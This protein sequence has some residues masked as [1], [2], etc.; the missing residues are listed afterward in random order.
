[1]FV[2]ALDSI[3]ICSE[4]LKRCPGLVVTQR[5]TEFENDY[6]MKNYTRPSNKK[7]TLQ[8]GAEETSQYARGQKRNSLFLYFRHDLCGGPKKKPF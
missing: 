7:N 8:C 6:L 2:S 5:E 3:S 4:R 1:M